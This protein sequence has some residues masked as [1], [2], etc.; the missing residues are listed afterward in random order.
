[1]GCSSS[2]ARSVENIS[3]DSTSCSKMDEKDDRLLVISD[4]TVSSSQM[5]REDEVLVKKAS[6]VCGIVINTQNLSTPKK[7]EDDLNEEFIWIVKSHFDKDLEQLQENG[8][9]YSSNAYANYLY[10]RKP[11][12]IKIHPD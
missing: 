3:N 5:N 9:V 12:T 4:D 6:P 2:V 1:M 7:P 11:R 8:Y 10:L